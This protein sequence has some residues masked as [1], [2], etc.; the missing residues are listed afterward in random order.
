MHNDLNE[1]QLYYTK[2]EKT[3]AEGCIPW[4]STYMTFWEKQNHKNW[5]QSGVCPELGGWAE[6]DQK[7]CRGTVGG[8]GDRNVLYFSCGDGYRIVHICQNSKSHAPKKVNY[9]VWKSS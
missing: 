5:K 3:G 2:W 7:V 6:T 8:E 1:S 4:D 9:I